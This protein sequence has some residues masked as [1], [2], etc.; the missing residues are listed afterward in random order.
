MD[1]SLLEH[2]LSAQS[3]R[4]NIESVGIDASMSSTDDESVET[5]IDIN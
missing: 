4:S 1:R 2:E 5:P 3:Q